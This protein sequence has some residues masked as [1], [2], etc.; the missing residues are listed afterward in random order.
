MIIKISYPYKNSINKIETKNIYIQT[1]DK[2]LI[3]SL[4]DTNNPIDIGAILSE[5]QNKFKKVS[6]QKEDEQII[7][8]DIITNPDL[9]F[10]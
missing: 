4:L 9:N 5:N 7:I 1:D 3:K 8:E 10:I 6:P 2:H